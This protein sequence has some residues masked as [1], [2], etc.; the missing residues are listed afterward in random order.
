M[1]EHFEYKCDWVFDKIVKCLIMVRVHHVVPFFIKLKA[2]IMSVLVLRVYVWEM[3]IINIK[4]ES[5]VHKTFHSWTQ[6]SY[7]LV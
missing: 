2:T 4:L 3:D 6:M 5:H 1:F 7:L